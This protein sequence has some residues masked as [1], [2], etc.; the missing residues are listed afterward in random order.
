MNGT[1]ISKFL[2]FPATIK[3]LGNFCSLGQIFYRK[4]SLGASIVLWMGIHFTCVIG[5]LLNLYS[6]LVLFGDNDL[7]S[8]GK[9]CYMFLAYMYTGVELFYVSGCLAGYQLE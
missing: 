3:N 6:G 1:D 4:Q 9:A 2:A 5:H 8:N 7:V